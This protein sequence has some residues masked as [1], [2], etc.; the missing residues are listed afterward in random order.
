MVDDN[1]PNPRGEE[2]PAVVINP[3]WP[4]VKIPSDNNANTDKQVDLTEQNFDTMLN[5]NSGEQTSSPTPPLSR[6][7]V[8]QL[9]TTTT[10]V[11]YEIHTREPD[12]VY[13]P[14]HRNNNNNNNQIINNS[15]KPVGLRG[16]E[17]KVNSDGK[18]L[19]YSVL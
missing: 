16:G 11:W 15:D 3:R 12:D 13:P 1:D 9:L 4:N 19:I 2:T 10:S 14:I 17:A 5:S 18:Q 8:E 6:P 7:Q